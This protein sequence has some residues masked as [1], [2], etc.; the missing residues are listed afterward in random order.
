[1]SR[2]KEE[3]VL[4]ICKLFFYTLILVQFCIGLSLSP[5]L[6]LWLTTLDIIHTWPLKVPVDIF[7]Y[8]NFVNETALFFTFDNKFITDY[9][10]HQK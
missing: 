2:D 1:M 9:P 3:H 5:E 4:N 6:Q 7:S 10:H 8:L